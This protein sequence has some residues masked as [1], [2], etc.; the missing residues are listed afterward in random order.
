VNSGEERQAEHG[1]PDDQKSNPEQDLRA[2]AQRGSRLS[3][4]THHEGARGEHGD[5]RGADHD[6]R[7]PPAH[8]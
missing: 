6:V 3:G 4:P 2:D 1:G 5:D 7:W 8:G